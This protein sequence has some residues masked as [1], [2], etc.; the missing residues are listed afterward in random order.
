MVAW[1]INLG[2]DAALTQMW[3]H[4]EYFKWIQGPGVVCGLA[5]AVKS[6]TPPPPP[7]AFLTPFLASTSFFTATLHHCG[8]VH[9]QLCR[10]TALVPVFSAVTSLL[11]SLLR[12]SDTS[13]S[14][15]NMVMPNCRSRIPLLD[16]TE[17]SS[18]CL[19]SSQMLVEGVSSFLSLVKDRPDVSCVFKR[20]ERSE[21][22]LN[23]SGC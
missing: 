18:V 17:A 12:H 14:H 16:N 21:S 20:L 11:W 15:S 3:L 4:V 19:N 7:H 2:F 6:S 23:T 22:S 13:T 1:W 8:L 10:V 5:L 9:F